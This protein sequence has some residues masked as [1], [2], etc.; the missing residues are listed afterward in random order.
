MILYYIRTY[1]DAHA[2][3]IIGFRLGG[4]GNSGESRFWDTV[5]FPQPHLQRNTDLL[6][7]KVRTQRYGYYRILLVLYKLAFDIFHG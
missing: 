6:P 1:T 7:E 4:L 3:N 5:T 2:W